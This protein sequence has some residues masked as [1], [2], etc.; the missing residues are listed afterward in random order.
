MIDA[1]ETLEDETHEPICCVQQACQARPARPRARLR[2]AGYP[3]LLAAVLSS[4]WMLLRA[5]VPEPL[6]L[7]VPALLLAASL[8]VLERVIPWEPAL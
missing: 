1:C 5:E 7:V 8:V 6:A 3:L 4:A 2:R